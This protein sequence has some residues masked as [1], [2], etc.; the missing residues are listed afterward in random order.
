MTALESPAALPARH[1]PEAAPARPGKSGR[2]G[3]GAG[4]RAILLYRARAA[5]DQ[6]QQLIT[7][8][9]LLAQA[10]VLAPASADSRRALLRGQP[11]RLRPEALHRSAY[12]RLLAQL[13]TMPVIEQAKGILMAQSR[14]S[15]AAEAFDLL[16]RASQ[17]S[18]IPVRELAAQL[19]ANTTRAPQARKVAD[20]V[21]ARRCYAA[22]TG[23]PPT[24]RRTN[25]QIGMLMRAH[26]GHHGHTR[27]HD[28]HI[29][30]SSAAC[31]I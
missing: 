1:A 19:V 7:E 13:E 3:Q 29:T 14:C 21:P 24:P 31:T 22:D 23:R 8:T 17:R 2:C 5:L 12:A 4:D 6:A 26:R 25:G 9:Q 10:Q 30:L 16:R 18:N 11:P 28:L 27:R 20:D 15:N